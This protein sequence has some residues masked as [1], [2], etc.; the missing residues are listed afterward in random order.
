MVQVG[1]DLYCTYMASKLEDAEYLES[2]LNIL[3]ESCDLFYN[4]PTE[5]KPHPSTTDICYA[6][7]GLTKPDDVYIFPSEENI[8]GVSLLDEQSKASIK[9]SNGN[10]TVLKLEEI[11]FTIFRDY[12]NTPKIA[13]AKYPGFFK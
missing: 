13:N 10:K 11:T 6:F 3:A 7:R 5:V 4:T 1:K 9:F 2:K 8:L 12:L